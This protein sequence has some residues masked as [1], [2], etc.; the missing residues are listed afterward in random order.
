MPSRHG[1][2][3]DSYGINGHHVHFILHT[4]YNLALHRLQ[5]YRS[6]ITREIPIYCDFEASEY[7]I[8]HTIERLAKDFVKQD[9]VYRLVV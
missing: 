1:N 5:S 8:G 4:F 7:D 3:A 6:F 9:F 2:R